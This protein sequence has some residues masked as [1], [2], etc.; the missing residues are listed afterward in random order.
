M[1]IESIEILHLSLLL[2]KSVY[3]LL[4]SIE[5]ELFFH[6]FTMKS[7]DEYI[8]FNLKLRVVLEILSLLS[9]IILIYM[10]REDSIIDSNKMILKKFIIPFYYH[11]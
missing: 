6:I 10:L 3:N 11:T 5:I 8:S 7:L 9:H 1:Y 2:L 4:L